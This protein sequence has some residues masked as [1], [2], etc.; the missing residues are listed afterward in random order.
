[1]HAGC[2]TARYC[3]SPQVRF[4]R[5]DLGTAKYLDVATGRLHPRAYRTA[6]PGGPVGPAAGGSGSLRRGRGA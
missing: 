4:N 6:R 2:A 3:L 5:L 1:M